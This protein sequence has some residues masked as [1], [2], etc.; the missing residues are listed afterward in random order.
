MKTTKTTKA[1]KSTK[2]T[3]AVKKVWKLS[4]EQKVI[5]EAIEAGNFIPAE[6]SVPVVL[7]LHVDPPAK[8][9]KT[10]QPSSTS[11]SAKVV[12][13]EDLEDLSTEEIAAEEYHAEKEQADSDD[14][15]A[16]HQRA[17]AAARSREKTNRADWRKRRSPSYVAD[18]ESL[19]AARERVVAMT[20]AFKVHSKYI[21][22]LLKS[23]YPLEHRKV[24]AGV[25]VEHAE[26]LNKAKK[27]LSMQYS[28]F[29]CTWF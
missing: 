10:A 27:Q 16:Y 9:T 8:N 14:L 11:K 12:R 2:S 6:L 5:V 7:K 22:I 15:F 21:K 4:P 26:T 25:L 3:K 29:L 23:Y 17:M 28:N 19:Y 24:L 1:V 18:C 13:S 20:E